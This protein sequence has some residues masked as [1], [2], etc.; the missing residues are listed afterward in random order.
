MHTWIAKV[1]KHL[2]RNTTI[3][4]K[5]RLYALICCS[6]YLA[7]GLSIYYMKFNWGWPDDDLGILVTNNEKTRPKCSS[8]WVRRL[9]W[10]G[11]EE[12]VIWKYCVAEAEKDR[13][14]RSE[15]RSQV[16]WLSPL[17]FRPIDRHFNLPSLTTSGYSPRFVSIEILVNSLSWRGLNFLSRRYM[18]LLSS[19][20]SHF[21]G[22]EFTTSEQRATDWQR[23]HY[24]IRNQLP[25]LI[26]SFIFHTLSFSVLRQL[27]NMLNLTSIFVSCLMPQAERWSAKV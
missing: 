26:T 5:L 4:T 1:E 13:T 24:S 15:R 12:A 7:Q 10:S 14:Q 3:F 11:I 6:C 8:H 19:M 2:A 9:L 20:T 25:N 17:H 21:K 16:G 22:L 27:K 23:K 18:R